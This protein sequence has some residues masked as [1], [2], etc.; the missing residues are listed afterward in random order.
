[1]SEL[2]WDDRSPLHQ[3]FIGWNLDNAVCAL[4]ANQSADRTLEPATAENA[5]SGGLEGH[6]VRPSMTGLNRKTRSVTCLSRS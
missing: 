1:M 4:F 6:D 3:A 2:P 5:D